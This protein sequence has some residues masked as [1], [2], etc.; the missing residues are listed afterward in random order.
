MI[1]QH[2]LEP[3]PDGAVTQRGDHR[4]VHTAREAAQHVTVPH[5]LLDLGDRAAQE[6]LH[7]PAA[8]ELR[9]AEEEVVDHPLA[10]G[11]M[12]HLGV[13]LDQVVGMDAVQRRRERAIRGVGDRDP[14]LAERLHLVAMAHPGAEA[15]RHACE[16]RRA[17]VDHERGRPVLGGLRLGDLPSHELRGRLEAVADPQQGFP[18]PVDARVRQRRFGA[19]AARRR[20]GE[21][22]RARLERR[23]VSDG[24][25]AGH[26]LGIDAGLAHAPRDQIR[27]LRAEIEDQ[28]PLARE[29]SRRVRRR[30]RGGR[31]ARRIRDRGHGC[32]F[33]D[34]RR[35]AP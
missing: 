2:A 32:P 8:F 20:A 19:I 13:E 12:H 5:L 6:A 28:H 29:A 25:S 21:D 9:D 22:E 26:D 23:D 14:V 11:R 17:L 3:A 34:G 16:Q 24:R 4:A 10:V 1:H 27:V 35:V 33:N 31:R 7:A 15:L 18:Q 30:A